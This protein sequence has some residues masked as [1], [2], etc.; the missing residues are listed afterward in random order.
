[1]QFRDDSDIN[2]GETGGAMIF[3]NSKCK[4]LLLGLLFVGAAMLSIEG[5]SCSKEEKSSTVMLADLPMLEDSIYVVI[6]V[7]INSQEYRF[8]IDTA[9]DGIAVD[10]RLKSLLGDFIKRKKLPITPRKIQI[11][12]ELYECPRRF[13]IGS[14]RL[15]GTIACLDLRKGG[16]PPDHNYDGIFGMNALHDK[17]LQFDL[18]NKRVR[19]LKWRKTASR[20]TD[21]LRQKWGH[22]VPIIEAEFGFPQINLTLAENIAELFL[23]DTGLGAHNRLRE[24][25]FDKLKGSDTIE[26]Y[27]YSKQEMEAL[28]R[29]QGIEIRPEDLKETEVVLVS[30]A[31]LPGIDLPNL[32]FEKR[33]RSILGIKF[34]RLFRM[35]TF[36]FE[37]NLLYL[38]PMA[39]DEAGNRESQGSRADFNSSSN[40]ESL[41]PDSASNTQESDV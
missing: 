8:I 3:R 20:N 27:H 26:Y 13:E 30:Q 14:V 35:I 24:S 2:V 12:A 23:V 17:V 40:A 38:K 32:W 34:V 11:D 33:R 22:P 19:L 41:P 37:N 18:E 25:T 10:S 29:E 1:M 21:D 36:D 28:A 9:G 7:T 31:S 5:C 4:T 39:C 16:L 6:P 15:R